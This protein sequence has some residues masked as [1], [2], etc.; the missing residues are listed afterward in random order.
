MQ[1]LTHKDIGA[2]AKLPIGP[3]TPALTYNPVILASPGRAVDIQV[4]VGAPAAGS[5][6][7]IVLLAHGQGRSNWLNSR[8]G[9]APVFDFLTGHGFVV[10]QPTQLSA[11]SLGVE[12]GEGD[13]LSWSDQPRTLRR[14]LDELDAIEEEVPFL[15]GRMDKSNIAVVGHSFGGW[16]ASQL[17]GA[18]NTDKRT[19]A[20]VCNFDERVKAGV[21]LGGL[22]GAEGLQDGA[23]AILP[24]FGPDF[25][26][27][28]APA[29][30]VCGEDDFNPHFCR[31]DAGWH[32]EPYRLAPGP[33]ELVWVKGGKHGFGGISGWDTNEVDDEGPERLFFVLRMVWAYLRSA[34]VRGDGAWGEAVKMLGGAKE[35]GTVESK[36]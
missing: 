4:K 24:F 2:A 22:G 14:I 7:P 16:A 20:T 13:E 8:H 17:L 26:T 25:S 19:G 11:V 9:Y 21:I 33:K 18:S 12:H 34:L 32:A 29:L 3:E 28:T 35:L 5:D 36:E 1:F 15:K 6:L 30:V 31:T 10:M 23:Q 27:M